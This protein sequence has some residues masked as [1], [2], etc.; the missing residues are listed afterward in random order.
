MRRNT[1]S[2]MDRF[3]AP[4]GVAAEL[5][6]SA[7]QTILVTGIYVAADPGGS[8]ELRRNSTL[9]VG[10]TFLA[11]AIVAHDQ[12]NPAAAGIVQLYTV[13]PAAGVVIGFFRSS[14]LLP[15]GVNSEEYPFGLQNLLSQ[16]MVLRGATDTVTV[17]TPLG[18]A[19]F[20][21]GFEWQE[22]LS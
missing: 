8:F 1:Y 20:N 10:G 18:I 2:V 15:G 9:A 13:A 19:V 21:A 5:R 4:A 3:S 14:N 7:T 17:F 11:P 12:N 22:E 16:P 6:G